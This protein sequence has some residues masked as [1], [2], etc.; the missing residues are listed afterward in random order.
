MTGWWLYVLECDGGVLYTGVATDVGRR[1][2]EHVSGKG[3]RFTRARK[4]VRLLYTEEHPNRSAAQVA[5]AA[6]KKLDRAAKLRR[7]AEAGVTSLPTL[8]RRRA[9]PRGKKPARR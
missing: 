8:S 3:A 4:P 5:E 9:R 6:F 7:L 2:D 1:Y